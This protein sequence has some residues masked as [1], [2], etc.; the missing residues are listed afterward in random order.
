[1][2]VTQHPGP[3]ELHTLPAVGAHR[4]VLVWLL[5][6]GDPHNCFFLSHWF[7]GLSPKETWGSLAYFRDEQP[8]GPEMGEVI[9]AAVSAAH[10]FLLC[11]NHGSHGAREAM[12]AGL[13]LCPSHLVTRL[14]PR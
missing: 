4:T 5:A 12:A 6:L 9:R 11:T 14:F 2:A 7:L 10:D 8:N 1:M 13:E 3:W